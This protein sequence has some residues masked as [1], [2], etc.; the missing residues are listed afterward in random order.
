MAAFIKLTHMAGSAK[1]DVYVNVE[2]IVRV[3]TPIDTKT[4]YQASL[5]LASGQQDV[6]ET[7]EEVMALIR[8]AAS[9]GA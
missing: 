5:V 8:A 2:Q 1:R 7:V 9:S 4:A 3:G 6:V